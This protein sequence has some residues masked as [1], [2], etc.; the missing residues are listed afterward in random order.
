MSKTEAR[1]SKI[2]EDFME[3]L[4]LIAALLVA[5]IA[6]NSARAFAGTKHIAG[7]SNKNCVVQTP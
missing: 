1:N 2:G 7:T 3:K 5:I 6:L 4:T